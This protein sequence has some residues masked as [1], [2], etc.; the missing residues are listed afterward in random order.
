MEV[1]HKQEM[2]TAPQAAHHVTVGLACSWIS[3]KPRAPR[4][5]DYL[6]SLAASTLDYRA[7]M[8]GTQHNPCCT[9]RATICKPELGRLIRNQILLPI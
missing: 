5:P 2:T 8:A 9:I 7:L 1:V 6:N 4:V 3:E